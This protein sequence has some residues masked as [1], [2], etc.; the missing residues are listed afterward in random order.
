MRTSLWLGPAGRHTLR[1]DDVDLDDIARLMNAI[2]YRQK[3]QITD[4]RRNIVGTWQAGELRGAA[5]E[6][7]RYTG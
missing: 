4:H 5:V 6:L 2:H 1:F 7:A 3:V